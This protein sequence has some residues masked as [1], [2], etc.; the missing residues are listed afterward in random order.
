MLGAKFPKDPQECPLEFLPARTC[1]L[2]KFHGRAPRA[3]AAR[4]CSA[5]SRRRFR[6]DAELVGDSAKKD[7]GDDAPELE[8]FSDIG[9]VA[10]NFSVQREPL[11]SARLQASKAEEV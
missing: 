4:A 6:G 10:T 1:R 7:E 3:A 2:L 5:D 11:D 8:A 9:C